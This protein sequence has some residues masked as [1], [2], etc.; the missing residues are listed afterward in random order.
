MKYL[1]TMPM[2]PLADEC[3]YELIDCS[4]AQYIL[5]DDRNF[6]LKNAG[7]YVVTNDTRQ[8]IRTSVLKIDAPV[9]YDFR[10]SYVYDNALEFIGDMYDSV[11]RV[12]PMDTYDI[13]KDTN[14]D[15]SPGLVEQRRGMRD[16]R[17]CIMNGVIHEYDRDVDA[18][19]KPL[20]KVSGKR[21]FQTRTNFVDNMKQRTFIIQPFKALWQTKREFGAQN[22]A[23]KMVGWSF[24]GHN[25]YEGGVEQL[26]KHLT[27]YSPLPKR[28]WE[29]DV[30]RW[31]R[32]LPHMEEIWQLRT[33]YKKSSTK[34][35]NLVKYMIESTLI[36]PEGHVIW[37]NWGNNSGSSTTTGDNI[38]GMSI[39][40]AHICLNLG[41]PPQGIHEH[42]SFAVFGDDVVGSDTLAVPDDLLRSIIEDT[43]SLYGLK[44]DPL[45]L[46]R[47]ITELHF[48]G[49][50]ITKTPRGYIP[51]YPLE[52]LSAA[53]LKN[54]SVMEPLAEYSKMCSLLV[55]SAGNGEEV[56]NF[57]RRALVTA[58]TSVQHPEFEK[59]RQTDLDNIIPQYDD[60]I[61]WYLGLEGSKSFNHLFE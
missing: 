34:I 48:L 57:F 51:Q 39:C 37:K 9:C 5:D 59:L 40:L 18:V 47:D 58:V 8:H 50:K 52:R 31:D 55:M 32:L 53:F 54:D 3:K 19:E 46:T 33:K 38:L 28:F 41:V 61:D 29:F 22:E 15:A 56:F 11:F 20:W 60:V 43:F 25:P 26:V 1:G 2:A 6:I 17:A 35:S 7:D 12:G 49:Y 27:S 10:K 36:T 44:L 4:I 24:Y 42:F 16:K 45:V 30:V 13:L 14:Y 21:E 23:I